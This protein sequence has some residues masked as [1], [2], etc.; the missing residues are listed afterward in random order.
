MIQILIHVLFSIFF[1]QSCSEVAI[2]EIWKSTMY[3]HVKDSAVS[4]QLDGKLKVN[5]I[6]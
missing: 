2:M 3:L 1:L 4:F 6:I 5:L